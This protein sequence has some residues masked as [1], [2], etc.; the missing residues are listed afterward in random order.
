MEV[1]I[2][3]VASDTNTHK[4]GSA[5]SQAFLKDKNLEIHA[6]GAGAVNQAVKGLVIARGFLASSGVGLAV[7]PFF[8]DLEVDSVMKTAVI[9]RLLEVK[10]AN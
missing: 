4:I 9:F 1:S 8:K 3:K 7:Q 6:V 10:N 2:F 5:I